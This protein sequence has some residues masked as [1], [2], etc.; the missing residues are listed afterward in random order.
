VLGH[1]SDVVGERGGLVARLGG[2][3]AEELGEGRTVLRILVDTELD[4]LAE[5]AVELVELLTVLGDLIEEFERLLDNILLDHLHD[6]VLLEGLT[7][8]VE[9]EI[10]RVDDTLD[11]AEPLGNEIGGIIGDEDTADIE[12]DV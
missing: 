11:E 12:L 8:Q 3:E 6:L 9:G 7:R 5:G 2:A 1:A 4:V 10:L